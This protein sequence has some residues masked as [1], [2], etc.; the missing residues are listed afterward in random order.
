MTVIKG[1][2]RIGEN[3]LISQKAFLDNAHMGDGSNAQENTYIINSHLMG[4]NVTAHGGKI[5]NAD[6]GQ[7]TF[8]GFNS[9]LFGKQSARLT[10]GK[11][12]IVMPHT[13]IDIEHPL[14]ILKNHI[15]WGYITCEEDLKTNTIAIEKLNEVSGKLTVGDL[16]FSGNGKAFIDAFMHRIEHILAANGAYC[17]H[18]EDYVG[19][20]QEGQQI[21]FNTLQPYRSGENEGLYPF[22]RIRP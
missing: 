18:D 15:I 6:I 1:D 3:V 21:S 7:K 20:A 12:C 4:M 10:I 2:T 14:Q 13:I 9:F 16:I 8:V 17:D 11:G 19:H 5:I 22:I